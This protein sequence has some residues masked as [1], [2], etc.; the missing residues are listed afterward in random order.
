M[1]ELICAFA[2]MVERNYERERTRCEIA[3]MWIG[4][5]VDGCKRD[6]LS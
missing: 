6:R 1:S 3:V 4:G 5:R 2:E